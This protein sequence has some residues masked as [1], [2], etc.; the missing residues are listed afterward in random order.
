[1]P[2]LLQIGGPL[3]LGVFA[4]VRAQRT[5]AGLAWAGGTLYL[6]FFLFRQGFC[7]YFYLV[8]AVYCIALAAHRSV[9][10]REG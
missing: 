9:A 6:V 2:K 10:T 4:V 5:P 3:L 8:I 1:M 7:N